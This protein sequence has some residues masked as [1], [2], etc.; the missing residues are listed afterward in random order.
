MRN[1]KFNLLFRFGWSVLAW[2]RSGFSSLVLVIS[3]YSAVVT[4][5]ERR[6]AEGKFHHL[7]VSVVSCGT[8]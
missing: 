7:F 4:G 6:G 2:T 3:I 1:K 8:V 5:E